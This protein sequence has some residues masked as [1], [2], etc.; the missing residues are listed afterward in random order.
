[1]NKVL[2]DPLPPELADA[3]SEISAEETKPTP[4]HP[5]GLHHRGSVEFMNGL[6]AHTTT[7]GYRP[8]TLPFR[9]RPKQKERITSPHDAR[10]LDLIVT[11]ADT[12]YTFYDPVYPWSA[13]GR[14]TSGRFPE[15]SF[16]GASG[17]MVGRRHLLTS[18]RIVGWEPNGPTDWLTFTPSYSF[19]A[20]P[21][22]SA[23]AVE[24][25]AWRQLDYFTDD[26]RHDL[27]ANDY[28]VV[29]L[30]HAIGESTGW[31]GSIA[32]NTTW[33]NQGYWSFIGYSS[34][35]GSGQEPVFQNLAAMTDVTVP[36]GSGPPSNA[37]LM[38]YAAWMGE[39]PE[40]EGGGPFFGWWSGDVGPRVVGVDTVY[41]EVF[42]PTS[43]RTY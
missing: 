14:V 18:S 32:Y 28:A 6:P 2:G 4:K 15:G 33:N 11:L 13:F 27:L 38:S 31:L 10:V 17:V 21:F 7:P 41:S 34:D 29:V 30:D 35:F 16:V 25:Y 24:I 20:A 19:G 12:R 9:A 22:G 39:F 23:Y 8:T 43:P 26:A 5:I 37:L 1:M 36:P 3:L 42:P 40:Y